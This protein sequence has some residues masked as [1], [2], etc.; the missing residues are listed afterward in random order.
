MTLYSPSNHIY[1]R[2]C[3]SAGNI[4]N[5]LLPHHFQSYSYFMF[6]VY[7]F[8]SW[9]CVSII[10]LHFHQWVILCQ[11][12]LY[13]SLR[14]HRCC[15]CLSLFHLCCLLFM[16][17]HLISP[18]CPWFPLW[19][20]VMLKIIFLWGNRNVWYLEMVEYFNLWSIS[21]FLIIYILLCIDKVWE[22]YGY[23]NIYSF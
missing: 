23:G 4:S 7:N 6:V 8:S 17:L 14:S 10:H 18:A 5:I 21:F 1:T 2:K 3:K 22:K 12:I 15:C 11:N 20:F 19:S 16:L 9:Y 13:Y